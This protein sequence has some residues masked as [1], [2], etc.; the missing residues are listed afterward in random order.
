MKRML[1]FFLVSL[2]LFPSFLFTA[3]DSDETKS[4]SYGSRR[5][6]VWITDVVD[7]ALKIRK[8]EGDYQAY[9]AL[10]RKESTAQM[11]ANDKSACKNAE[12]A[13]VTA[14]EAR[15]QYQLI[16]DQAALAS[17]PVEWLRAHFSWVRYGKEWD[18]TDN[19]TIHSGK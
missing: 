19:I 15:G 10:C 1:P 9:A 12:Q 6:D 4:Q 17:V 5:Q 13:L 11:N 3:D 2:V 18:R 16:L 7:V 14:K 8:A